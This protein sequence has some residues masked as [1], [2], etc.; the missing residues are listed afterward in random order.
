LLLHSGFSRASIAV[1]SREMWPTGRSSWVRLISTSCKRLGEA[2]AEARSRGNAGYALA[3][4]VRYN[5]RSAAERLNGGL[6][7]DFG[8][9]YVRCAAAKVCCHL[10]FGVLALAIDHLMRLVT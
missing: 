9:R 4:D 2:A 3:E 5:E 1:A 6:K 8:K 7:D 10:M